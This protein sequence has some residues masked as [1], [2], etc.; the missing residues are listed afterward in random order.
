MT[1]ADT[2]LRVENTSL[3]LLAGD[4]AD[5]ILSLPLSSLDTDALAR[6][7]KL[8]KLAA[9]VLEDTR[10]APGS[11]TAAHGE[12]NGNAKLTPEVVGVMRTLRGAGYTYTQIAKR[13]G[14]SESTVRRA[15]KGQSW[16]HL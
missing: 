5:F 8:L 9:E 2:V 15:A 10:W 14:V 4:L 16:S 7:H 13:I 6:R 3:R 11:P 1:T 12:H